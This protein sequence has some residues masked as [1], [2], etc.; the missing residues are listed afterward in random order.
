MQ[1]TKKKYNNPNPTILLHAGFRAGSRDCDA[2]RVGA[3]WAGPPLRPGRSL[4]PRAPPAAG[5]ALRARAGP[6]AERPLGTRP[7]RR[8]AAAEAV[9]G[10]G[11]TPAF[12]HPLLLPGKGKTREAEQRRIP[13]R[14][15]D[16]GAGGGG[17]R[18]G[19]DRPHESIL[20]PGAGRPRG[21]RQ[22]PF[23]PPEV[24]AK[25]HP[26]CSSRGTRG[27]PRG[28]ARVGARSG[29]R[30]LRGAGGAGR[31]LGES[32]PAA[33]REPAGPGPRVGRSGE[34]WVARG[35][36]D[37]LQEACSRSLLGSIASTSLSPGKEKATV[38]QNREAS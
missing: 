25:C 1:R 3:L 20:Q 31:E 34:R 38:N 16:R 36:G 10:A 4:T 30:H 27:G 8:S 11:R 5:S 14:E 29:G 7:S 35:G 28:A 23:R 21:C 9:G 2:A 33:R 19:P 15:A 18:G 6:W 24:L 17:R 12:P 22:G 13:T 32:S 37:L 26:P